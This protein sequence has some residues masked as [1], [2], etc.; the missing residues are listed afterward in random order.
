M[1]N[2]DVAGDLQTGS[3]PN[4]GIFCIPD[5]RDLG[6]GWLVSLAFMYGLVKLSG[7]KI[8]SDEWAPMG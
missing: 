1:S 5:I 4:H 8:H 2:V 7:F 3:L 6:K